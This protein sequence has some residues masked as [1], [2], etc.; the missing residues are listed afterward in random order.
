M[1]HPRYE[2]R[3]ALIPILSTLITWEQNIAICSLF[4][5]K[6][7]TKKSASLCNL[8][9]KNILLLLI[10]LTLLISELGNL[11]MGNNFLSNCCLVQQRKWGSSMSSSMSCS[12]TARKTLAC[13]CELALFDSSFIFYQQIDILLSLT[14]SHLMITVK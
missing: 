5:I 7:I 6:L 9:V 13:S 3:S 14:H 12:W 1:L 2:S 8:V 10:M 4:K 11:V